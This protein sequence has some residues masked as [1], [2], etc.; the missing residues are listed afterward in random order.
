[1][2]IEALK[3]L[4]DRVSHSL[5]H[6]NELPCT[7]TQIDLPPHTSNIWFVYLSGDKLYTAADKTLYVYLVRNNKSPI[8]TY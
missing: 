7:I 4:E 3:D 5:L 8:A 2:S 6:R 1:M